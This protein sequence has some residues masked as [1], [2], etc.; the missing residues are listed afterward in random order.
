[1]MSASKML[2]KF[3]PYVIRFMLFRQLPEILPALVLTRTSVR[4]NFDASEPWHKLFVPLCYHTHE[5]VVEV[6]VA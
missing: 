1:M 6:S 2:L 4:Q 3:H 5:A